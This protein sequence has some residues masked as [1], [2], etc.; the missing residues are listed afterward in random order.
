MARESLNKT[1]F[2]DQNLKQVLDLLVRI[3][4]LKEI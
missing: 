4:A 2:K 3:F 1:K